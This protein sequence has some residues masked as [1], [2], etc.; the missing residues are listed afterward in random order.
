MNVAVT[1]GAEGFGR[2]VFTVREVKR[3]LLAGVLK[4]EEKFELIEGEIVPMSPKGNQHEVIKS[5]LTRIIARH[6]SDDLRL[7]VESSI[8][9]SMTTF[10]EPDLCLY[11][12]RLLPEDVRGPDLVLVIEIAGSSLGYDKGLKGRLYASHG[13]QELWVI[14]ASKRAAWIHR[15][16]NFDGTWRSI[17]EKAADAPLETSALP[18]VTIVLADLQ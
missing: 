13:V 2:R 12:M 11:P 18:G 8:Y 10:V 17:E 14:D 9:L 16:P 6:A 7:G 5:A 4:E 3:M 1:R 15:G